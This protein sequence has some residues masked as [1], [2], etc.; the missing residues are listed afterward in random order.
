MPGR[1]RTAI[2]AQG[3]FAGVRST[4]I[5]TETASTRKWIIFQVDRGQQ[6]QVEPKNFN[7]NLD[8]TGWVK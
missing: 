1:L 5:A 4:Q 3:P 8:R 7:A 6:V 2:L